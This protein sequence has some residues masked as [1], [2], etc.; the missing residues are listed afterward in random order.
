MEICM[1][2]DEVQ[3]TAAEALPCPFCGVLPS[4]EAWHGGG[5]EKQMI[6]CP[7]LDCDVSPQVTGETR[8]EALENWNRRDSIRM[9]KTGEL[10][11][12]PEEELKEIH[13]GLLAIAEEARTQFAIEAQREI[14]HRR[15]F[16][17]GRAVEI[18]RSMDQHPDWWDYGCLCH[19]CATCG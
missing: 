3:L 16:L 12:T 14:A 2:D 19:E 11:A 10:L 7:N 17:E 13:N 8:T 5:P 4:I 9:A 15:G 6:G 1:S 18:T